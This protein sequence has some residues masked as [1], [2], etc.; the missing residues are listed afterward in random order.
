M[1][2]GQFLTMPG[3]G[4]ILVSLLLLVGSAGGAPL[5]ILLAPPGTAVGLRAYALGM[6]PIE[7]DFTRFRGTLRVEPATGAG[8]LER[9]TVE[10]TIEAASL[11]IA[12]P[13]MRADVLS[14]TFLDAAAFPT[15]AYRG[16]CA[17][18]GFRGLLTMHGQTHALEL[19]IERDGTE[20]V[21]TGLV[22]RADWGMAERPF[23]VGP[24]VRIR[25][26]TP[27]PPGW[28]AR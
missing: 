2:E 27:W 15:L 10:L 7:G 16:A 18:G 1:G 23:M 6:L 4:A 22:R 28:S 26:T 12:D 9:C 25:V 11:F 21:A 13:Q 8:E 17:S 3:S 5:E 19:T 14:P 24:T 20:L